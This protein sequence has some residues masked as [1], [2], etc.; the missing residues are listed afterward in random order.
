M[1]EILIGQ[2]PEAIYFSLFM[3]FAKNLKSKRIL[4]TVLMVAEYLLLKQFINF[5]IWF[6][7]IYTFMTFVI[8]KVLYKEKAQVT[9]IFT[10]AIGSV[11]L[12]IISIVSY[13]IVWKT[14]NIYYVA[15]ALNRILIILFL[16]LTYN[17]L[18]K[19][20]NLYKRF[21]NRND[22]IKKKM[23]STTFRALNLVIFNI[24]FYIINICM[25]FI[26]RQN[27]GV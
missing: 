21:W 14:V 11:V 20:Q 27:G 13:F 10:F 16:I 26:I 8:L 18:Y 19:I 12:M 9:D 3:I 25:I 7:I 2:I 6:Q 1:L 22:K 4:F 15:L 23:K 5:N 24:M 17:K